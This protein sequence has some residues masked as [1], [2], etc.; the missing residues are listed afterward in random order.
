MVMVLLV[1]PWASS[2][3]NLRNE[4]TYQLDSLQT[5]RARCT[6]NKEVL[7]L[8]N[9]ERISGVCSDRSEGMVEA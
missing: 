3:V 8:L 9:E 6:L 2:M 1:L 5:N 4:G 7:D